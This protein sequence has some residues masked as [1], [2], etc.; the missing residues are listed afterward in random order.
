MANKRIFWAILFFSLPTLLYAGAWV[1]PAGEGLNILTVRRYLSDQYWTP[2]GR[3]VSSP[4]YA[5]NEIDEYFEY[6]VTNRLTL[7]L[8]F[9]ALKSHT[10]AMGTQGGVNDTKLLGRYLLW[11]NDS[12]VFSIQLG[13]NKLG[14][15][16]AFN[17]PPQNSS[18]NSEE[19]LLIGTSG[20]LAKNTTNYWFADAS[21][22]LIQ[23]YSAGNQLQ[24]NLE[25]GAKFKD[26]K[27]WLML[28]NYNTFN[29]DHINYPQGVGYNIM[30]LAPSILYWPYK[31]VGL[32]AGVAQD[33]YG[34]NVGKGRAFFLA[35]WIRI[36][37]NHKE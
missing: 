12:S 37:E 15:A 9:S 18:F 17:I 20:V 34:Q 4:T 5:K 21:F 6:G 22:G 14:R 29:T 32:Q 10:S 3:L 13:A 23:R 30:T 2:A 25:A 8:Y 35:T 11:K 7:A 19:S 31:R 28:Q 1:Q 33:I 16:A 24:I 36:G 26:D 27:L